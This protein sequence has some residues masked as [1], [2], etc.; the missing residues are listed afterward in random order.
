MEEKTKGGRE[1]M[2]NLVFLIWMILFPIIDDVLN[3]V[4]FKLNVPMKKYTDTTEGIAA[5]IQILVWLIV[6]ALLYEGR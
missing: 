6:G 2:K 1:K 5:L 3:I 4:R